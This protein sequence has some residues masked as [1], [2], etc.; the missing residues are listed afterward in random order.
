MNS[1]LGAWSPD[2]TRLAYLGSEA[3]GN[4]GLYVADVTPAA[5]WP[6]TS[7]DG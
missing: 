5:R 7:R 2:G 6:A 4:A 1:L 3:T